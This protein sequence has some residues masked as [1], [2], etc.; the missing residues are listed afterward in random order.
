[1][2]HTYVASRRGGNFTGKTAIFLCDA[3]VFGLLLWAWHSCYPEMNQEIKDRIFV[4]RQ[5]QVI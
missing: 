1:M 5:S 3:C 4:Q 2:F